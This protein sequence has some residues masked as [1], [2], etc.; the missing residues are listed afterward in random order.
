[1]DSGTISSKSVI[2]LASPG[3]EEQAGQGPAATDQGG[4]SDLMGLEFLLERLQ[5]QPVAGNPENRAGSASQVKMWAAYHLIDRWQEHCDQFMEQLW[6]QPQEEIRESAINLIGKYRLRQYAFPLL[7]LLKQHDSPLKPLAAVALGRLRHETAEKLL[8]DWLEAILTDEEPNPALL[9]AAAESLL[10]FD[11][12]S[13]WEKVYALLGRFTHNHSLFSAIF[14]LLATHAQTPRQLERLAQAYGKARELFRDVQFSLRLVE[15]VG[16]SHLVRYVQARLNGGYPLSTVYQECLKVLGLEAA[17][18]RA[19]E[20]LD[21]LGECRNNRQ[22]MERFYAVSAE[23]MDCF[24]PGGEG[25]ERERAFIQGCRGWI[26][27]WE[28]SIIKLRETEYHLLISLPLGAMLRSIERECLTA[29]EQNALR[30]TRIYSSPLLSPEFMGRV[31]ELIATRPGATVAVRTDPTGVTG[32]VR[33][34][35]KEALWKMFTGQLEDVDYPFEQVLPQPWLYRVP[36]LL[37]RL[38]ELLRSRFGSYLATGRE[39]AVDYAL[40]VFRRAGDTMI[41]PEL[42]A[43]F[44]VLINRH[45]YAFVEYMTHI[46]DIRFLEPLDGHLREGEED[47]LQLIRFICDVH[48][49]P[50]PRLA[51][52]PSFAEE[53]AVAREQKAAFGGAVVVRLT[54]PDC[55]SAYQ[56][57]L[58]RLYVN[59]ERIEQRRLPTA[60]DLWST[61][62]PDCKNCGRPV[63]LV[64]D[65][66]FLA[67]LFSELLALRMMKREENAGHDL[68]SIVLVQFPRVDG[69]PRHPAEF[70]RLLEGCRDDERGALML[71]WGRF[72]LDIGEVEEARG[73]FT[74]LLAGP[75][76]CPEAHYY[77]GVIAFNEKNL[78]EARVH[79]SRLVQACGRGEFE[80]R[81]DNPVDMA[82]HYLKLLD[83]RDFKRSHFR[84]I[85]T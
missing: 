43:N 40:E 53:A 26:A 35:E 41:V 55:G 27:D 10:F 14:G 7:R 15:A 50:Y 28:E 54:C 34:E 39:E 82:E 1:V 48:G 65:E 11:N 49:R 5:D 3:G 42:L 74:G 44:Q 79:F 13:N 36:T 84:I 80:N 71:E 47:L 12:R 83:K 4:G 69:G 31:L 19:R 59:E 60:N 57:R 70:R 2:Q 77:L 58:E 16:Q 23:L 62:E 67:E 29:P 33:D 76:P 37:E 18:G 32:W 46:P 61:T 81:Q 63:P 24:F 25:T 9:E 6:E 17:Q 52:Q 20:L 68:A 56:Y 75:D 45:Y 30:I 72:K 51:R 73:L 85:S 78:F 38:L 66:R 8:N 22:G 21:A 64:P